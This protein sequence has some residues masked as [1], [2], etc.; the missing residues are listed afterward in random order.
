MGTSK[1]ANAEVF[2]LLLYILFFVNNSEHLKVEILIEKR[3]KKF[4][5]LFGA[6]NDSRSRQ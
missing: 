5:K 6:R 3:I 2:L 1:E 4:S